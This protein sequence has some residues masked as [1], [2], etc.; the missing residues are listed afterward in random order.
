MVQLLRDDRLQA[1]KGWTFRVSDD[2]VYRPPAL[3]EV[4][5][6]KGYSTHCVAGALVPEQSQDESISADQTETRA[7]R[8]LVATG[9]FFFKYRDVASPLVFCSL[10]FGTKPTVLGGSRRLDLML[11]GLGIAL[12]LTGQLLRILVIGFAYVK[13]GG[14]KKHVYAETLVQEGFFAHCRNPLYL[15]NLLTVVGLVM[16]H[17]GVWLYLVGIAFFLLVYASITA[18]EED[19]LQ[20]K[21]GRRYEDYCARG[22]VLC[23]ILRRAGQDPQGNEIR[24]EEDDSEGVRKHLHVSYPRPGTAGMGGHSL[25]WLPIGLRSNLGSD[26]RVDSDCD[27][28]LCGANRKE[29]RCFGHRLSWAGCPVYCQETAPALACFTLDTSDFPPRRKRL[30]ASAQ[31]SVPWFCCLAGPTSGMLLA[32]EKI[33]VLRS[34]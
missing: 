28:I 3:N 27:G 25:R 24:L 20:K 26:A 15:G 11:D 17:N 10:A 13:R 4:F 18:A 34:Q 21:F 12:G 23:H 14:K 33:A 32:Q 30:T 16:I 19:Y 22:A 6:P 31:T 9:K 1:A 29:S 2:S 8:L 7:S 5:P